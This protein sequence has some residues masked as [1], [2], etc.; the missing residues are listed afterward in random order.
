MEKQA[1]ITLLLFQ[2]KLTNVFAA[3]RALLC[4]LNKMYR[5]LH[6]ITDE[7]KMYFPHSLQYVC[8]IDS[9]LPVKT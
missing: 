7:R 9:V 4:D 3:D 2:H 5:V 6:M 1:V 8:I